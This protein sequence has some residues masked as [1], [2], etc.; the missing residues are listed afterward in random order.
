METR[1]RLP[2]ERSATMTVRP[3]AL[4]VRRNSLRPNAR[5]K[6]GTTHLLGPGYCAFIDKYSQWEQCSTAYR[7]RLDNS[8]GVSVNRRDS[9]GSFFLRELHCAL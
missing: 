8:R 7:F 6:N 5:A 2:T 9:A 1:T 3:R 4:L